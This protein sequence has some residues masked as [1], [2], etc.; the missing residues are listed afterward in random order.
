M[1][2]MIKGNN[3]RITLVKFGQIPN[4]HYF[5]TAFEPLLVTGD[6]GNEYNVIPSAQFK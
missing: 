3:I 2:A 6:D 4:S 1:Q 5:D